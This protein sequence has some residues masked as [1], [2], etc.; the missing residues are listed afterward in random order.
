MHHDKHL[1]LAQAQR[2][3]AVPPEAP[4][5]VAGVMSSVPAVTEL[6]SVVAGLPNGALVLPGLDQSLD[7]E[8]W[9]TIV[10]AASRASPVRPQE[11]AGCAGRAAR[12]RA[13]AAGADARCGAAAR[14]RPS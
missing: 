7:E 3:R 10:P 11:A 8:S 2:L 6:L 14:A 5:I 1:V 4:V 13:A 12:G 9:N